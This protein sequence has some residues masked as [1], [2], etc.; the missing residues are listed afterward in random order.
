MSTPAKLSIVKPK[1]A[2][3]R[4]TQTTMDT[5]A[6]SRDQVNGWKNPPFQRPLRVNARVKEIAD[7]IRGDE[8]IPGIIT[9]GVMG[10]STYLLDGQHRREAFLI[11]GVEVGY[12]DV[13]VHHFDAMAD[14]GREFVQLNSRISTLR[15][16]DI[17]RGMEGSVEALALIRKECPFVGYDMIRRGPTAPILSMSLLLRAWYAARAEVPTPSGHSAMSMA[18]TITVDSALQLVKFLK[19]AFGAWGRDHEYQ[20]LW[21]S[22]NMTMVMWLYKR[23]VLDDDDKRYPGIND[24]VFVKGMMSLSADAG[25]LSWLVGRLLHERDRSPAYTRVKN[26]LARRFEHELGRKVRLPQPGWASK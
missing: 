5:I 21:S 16:D 6:V 15:P 13:R 22:L 24:Q 8:V 2:P 14:M 26:I 17:L 9:L 19:M 3:Q 11:S 23:V 12:C 18:E 20:R 10:G 7:Q 1:T 4:A 25:Y